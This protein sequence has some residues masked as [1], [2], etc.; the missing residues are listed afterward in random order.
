[1]SDDLNLQRVDSMVSEF[2][3]GLARDEEDGIKNYLISVGWRPPN[4]PDINWHKI[5]G[6]EVWEDGGRYLIRLK[7]RHSRQEETATYN[8][9]H[10]H[11]HPFVTSDENYSLLGITHYAKIG[12]AEQ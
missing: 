4:S 2:A 1:M 12:E 5:T 8:G 9:K 3:Y 10:N 11:N 6:D 7:H